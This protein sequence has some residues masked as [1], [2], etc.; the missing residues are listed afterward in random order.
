MLST[1]IE[2]WSRD[3][4]QRGLQQG[5]QQGMQI[6]EQQG[7]SKLLYRLLLRKF[8]ALPPWVSQRLSDADA[9]QLEAW[10]DRI[11]D[12]ESLEEIFEEK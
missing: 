2:Q 4:E 12:A 5:M 7:E 1:R 6:G 9:Q 3:L 8:H 11:F 10:S